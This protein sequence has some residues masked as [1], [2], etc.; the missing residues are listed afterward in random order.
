[1][2]NLHPNIS[3]PSS[4][5]S[6]DNSPADL[7]TATKWRFKGHLYCT[8]GLWSAKD[9]VLAAVQEQHLPNIFK[10]GWPDLNK[11]S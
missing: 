7:E 8:A 1:M 4:Y 6:S 2:S 5:K 10:A 9:A 3:E 11:S